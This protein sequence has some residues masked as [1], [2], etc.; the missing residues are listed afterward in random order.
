MGTESQKI[1][2]WKLDY[3]DT[4]PEALSDYLKLEAVSGW[5]VHLIQPTLFSND[6]YSPKK[7]LMAVVIF[8]K[9]E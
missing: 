4:N 1:V 7:L 5:C 8:T 6:P 3:N 9:Y 2:T